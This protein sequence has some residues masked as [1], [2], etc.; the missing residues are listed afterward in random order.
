[1]YLSWFLFG[2]L[3]LGCQVKS[4]EETDELVAGHSRATNEF[5]FTTP[6]QTIYKVNEEIQFTLK[7][8]AVLEVIGT[9][10]LSFDI[11]GS[12][13]VA[14]YDSGSGSKNLVFKYIVQ[15]G[16][17]DTDGVTL[18][19][20]ID[21]NGGTITF[22][23]GTH[24]APTTF[25]TL[26]TI[27]KVD[28]SAPVVTSLISPLLP[29]YDLG[30]QFSIGLLFNEKITVTGSPQ[31]EMNLGGTI[32]NL[33]YLTGS[34][35]TTLY[36]SY[37]VATNDKDLNGLYF[38][39][40]VQVN[41]SD[42]K[43]SAGNH[44]LGTF[45]AT[46]I[47]STYVHWLPTKVSSISLPIDGIYQSGQSVQFTLSFNRTVTVLG[48]P[49]LSLEVG[50]SNVYAN[51]TSGSGTSQLTFTYIVG[52]GHSDTN[53]IV[54]DELIDLNGGTI[55][56]SLG[57]P[58]FVLNFDE[59]NTSSINVDGI[60]PTITGLQ[61]PT[62]GTYLLGS[63]LSFIMTFSESVTITNSPRLV[64]NI[65]GA[66][67]Y[68]NSISPSGSQATSHT[69]SYTV[70]SG[71][72]DLDGISIT[73]LDLN[74]GT[75]RDQSLNNS[76]ITLP[77]VNTTGILVNA[78]AASIVSLT[79]PTNA[80][81]LLSQNLN[82]IA[83]YSGIVTVVGSPRI[84]V[85]TAN[86]TLHA[87]YVSGSGTNSLTFRLTVANGD[88]DYDGISIANTIDLNGGGI[89]DSNS[90][91]ANLVFTVP[92][93]SNIFIDASPAL[94]TN[95]TK[96]TGATYGEGQ[97]LNFIFQFS[98]NVTVVGS[99]RLNIDLESGSVFATYFSGSGSSNLT[100]RYT[101]PSG[102]YDTNGV[103]LSSPLNLNGGTIRDFNLINATLTFAPPNTS[104][105][106]I[107][108]EVPRVSSVTAPSNNTYLT[109][110]NLNFT[111]D[112]NETVNVIG[113]PRLTLNIGGTTRYANYLSGSGSSTLVFRS[114]VISNDVDTNGISI[115]NSID[116]NGGSITDSSSNFASLSFTPP[117]L[118]QVKVDALLP[119]ISSVLVPS[120][121]IYTSGQ[122]LNFTVTY[123]KS[124]IV[125]GTPRIHLNINGTTKYADYLSGS[126]TSA[127]VFSY[128]VTASDFDLNGI[129][130][131]NS[132][133]IDLNSGSI[134]DAV[135]NDAARNLSGV[136]T[137][138]KV[139]YPGLSAWYDVTNTNSI[140]TSFV[141]PNYQ[142]TN[143]NDLTVNSRHLSQATAA[144]RPYYLSSG[145]GSLNQP[146]IQNGST[147]FMSLAANVSNLQYII[148]IFKTPATS[149][150]AGIFSSNTTTVFGTN[151]SWRLSFNTAAFWKLNGGALS[152]TAVTNTAN[153]AITASTCYVV[154]AK[155]STAQTPATQRLG[156]ASFLGQ[157]S[158]MIIFN[159]TAILNNTELT[160]IHNY[161]NSKYG[162]Y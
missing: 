153:N 39:G 147:D 99:P 34:G 77:S 45:T 6:S 58:V 93:T 21:L 151:T 148:T 13:K 49:R 104:T 54:L 95:I 87:T 11:G 157:I 98:K 50:S 4:E 38:P 24:S 134:K 56:D 113:T 65:G 17:N 68:A 70:A 132:N 66:T 112:F 130:Y 137:N 22:N 9:P 102:V 131:A 116:L 52:S 149:A 138:V 119:T 43:D 71:D 152:G 110:Q 29:L 150:A 78:N 101:I 25:S 32:K 159:N 30:D 133:E 85:T 23:N 126:G 124:V 114:T 94:I 69:F 28:T 74:G 2:I 156:H 5:I 125:T 72:L 40:N 120:D 60:I 83:L 145:F 90:Y 14:I 55:V 35:T 80:T 16:D 59:Q 100:F 146:F 105:I 154:S 7:H 123:T 26:N 46:T 111:F 44:F 62:N 57:D 1:M 135:N 160:T 10:S 89:T 37:T 128:A 41:S 53:G 19:S 92:N 96:P 33:N 127:L 67:I 121:G 103:S 15:P 61:I 162:C 75:I 142:V 115:N 48:T 36:F 82:F 51:Y 18:P 117:D 107:D 8:P 84:A 86:G 141:S 109:N 76:S 158:E 118:T 140:T 91:S 31:L 47:N 12:S 63:T 81:Y 106:L 3:L 27:L 79:P 88:Y 20:S 129:E 73:S 144:N 155:Y 97:V 136:L 139:S 161:L 143:W 108:A 42:I 64:L 122:N